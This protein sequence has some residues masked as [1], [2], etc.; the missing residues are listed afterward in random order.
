MTTSAAVT[1]LRSSIVTTDLIY[2]GIMTSL[3]SSHN[4][5]PCI[6]VTTDLIYKG[7]MTGLLQTQP[8]LFRV[9]YN[10]PD[11]QRDYDYRA[12]KPARAAAP[13]VTTDLIYKGIMTNSFTLHI[14]SFPTR[15]QQ[16]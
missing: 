11:L 3:A 8:V 13:R 6:A 16:T 2:K 10:R 5:T 4:K 9:R 14:I 15:L 1:G 12:G 7:I